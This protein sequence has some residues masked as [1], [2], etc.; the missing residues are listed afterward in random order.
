MSEPYQY[1]VTRRLQVELATGEMSA[2]TQRLLV[3]DDGDKEAELSGEAY[4]G[5]LAV[6]SGVVTAGGTLLLTDPYGFHAKR[7]QDE[8]RATASAAD[9]AATDEYYPSDVYDVRNTNLYYGKTASGTGA[10]ATGAT[11]AGAAGCTAAAGTDRSD[12]SGFSFTKLPLPRPGEASDGVPSVVVNGVRAEAR[13]EKRKS[14]LSGIMAVEEARR[15]R[16]A[17]L[18]GK[19]SALRVFVSFAPTKAAPVPLSIP[20]SSTIEAIVTAT[21]EAFNADPSR[22]TKL[23]PDARFYQLRLT[24]DDAGTPDTD[25][26]PLERTQMLRNIG[27]TDFALVVNP[28]APA[29]RLA[30]G[31]GTS[32]RR[33]VVFAAADQVKDGEICLRIELPDKTTSAVIVPEELTVGQFITTVCRKRSLGSDFVDAYIPG[34]SVALNKGLVL[35]DLG[36][37]E[38]SLEASTPTSLAAARRNSVAAAAST[39]TGDFNHMFNQFTAIIYK[40]YE[41]TKINKAGKRQPRVLGIDDKRIT[42]KIPES[43]K[44]SGLMSRFAK[45][46]PKRPFRNVDEIINIEHSEHLADGKAFSIYFRGDEHTDYEAISRSQASEIVAKI[47]YLM[48]MAESSER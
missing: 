14:A 10:V 31:G 23:E 27:C 45:K 19:A 12:A 24:D 8:G 30:S 43:E 41:V 25:L 47:T 17:H 44:K 28:K 36:A 2:T 4:T 5:P 38:I 7:E 48:G 22:D 26:P 46:N 34:I 33:S 42:N 13:A 35:R 18:A 11:G 39:D 1:A 32:K 6:T 15:R 37:T 21:I 9:L 3:D 20:Q 40:E 29:A 16:T